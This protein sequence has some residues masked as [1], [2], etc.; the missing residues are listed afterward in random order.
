MK[1][2]F[3][4][5]VLFATA[6]GLWSQAVV[7]DPTSMA[8]RIALFLEEMEETVSQSMDLADNSENTLKLL[9]ISKETAE[10]LVKVSNYIKTSRQIVEIAEAEIRIAEKLKDYSAKIKEME[11][12]TLTEKLNM[13]NSMVNLGSEAMKRI[14]SAMD[15]VKNGS[16]DAKLS[17]YE[18]LQI[19]TQVESE[20][21][22]IENAI[23][24]SYE[25]CLTSESI[26][27]IK[28]T[29]ENLCFSAMM[30]FP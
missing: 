16:S 26:E 21:L 13:I 27:D 11:S 23:D 8:Q 22:A 15:M 20:V 6:L 3:T 1:R 10:S 2:I 19:L 18:R 4:T 24:S 30:F 14:K 7:T 25:K 28:S 17:D 9:R 5:L 12:S 29:L